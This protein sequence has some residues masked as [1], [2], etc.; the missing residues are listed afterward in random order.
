MLF[1]CFAS[2]DFF[3]IFPTLKFLTAEVR[4]HGWRPKKILAE[5]VSAQVFENVLERAKDLP[6]DHT[7]NIL[8]TLAGRKKDDL[9]RKIAQAVA[10]I[11]SET[12]WADIKPLLIG[13]AVR[14]GM[15][16]VLYSATVWTL[17]WLIRQ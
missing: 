5:T 6:V 16:F 17:V 3:R 15:L 4:R 14:C 13:F 12:S 7:Q 10:V 8:L 1:F 2:Y 9:T 11:A